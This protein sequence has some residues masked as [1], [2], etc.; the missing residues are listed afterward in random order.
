M[1]IRIISK[2]AIWNYC[3]DNASSI[4]SFHVFLNRLEN[5]NWNDLNEIKLDFP[6]MSLVKDCEN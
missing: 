2:E 1:K 4:P 3:K 5:C 6:K